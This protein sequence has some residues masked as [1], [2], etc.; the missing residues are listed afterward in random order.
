MLNKLDAELTLVLYG[1]LK[2]PV[3]SVAGSHCVP[4]YF[5][6]CPE[7]GAVELTTLP[8]NAATVGLG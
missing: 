3:L 4:L 1:R 7:A 6:T 5:N 2:E 8:R